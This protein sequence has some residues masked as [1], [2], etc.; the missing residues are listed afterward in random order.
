MFRSVDW[1]H[2][3]IIVKWREVTWSDTYSIYPKAEFARICPNIYRMFRSVDSTHD[4]IIVKW[5]LFIWHV[6]KLCALTYAPPVQSTEAGLWL[7]TLFHVNFH[8]NCSAAQ[9][10]VLHPRQFIFALSC[11][12]LSFLQVLQST[13]W[14]L[15]VLFVYLMMT[16]VM[17]KT[18][19]NQ[20]IIKISNLIQAMKSSACPKPKVIRRPN[21]SESRICPNIYRMFRSVDWTHDMIIVKWHLFI[22][23]ERKLCALTNAPPVQSTQTGQWLS[24]LFHANCSAAQVYVLYPRQFIFAPSCRRPPFLQV[25]Q[26]T[27]C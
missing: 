25:L 24:T 11:R 19:L 1:T 6:R 17:M 23:Q 20:K 2:D 16:N 22:W 10:Y 18:C 15:R 26:S 3:M 12:G 13:S 14:A 5:H 4:I 9:V 7:S 21:F 27:D 8:A